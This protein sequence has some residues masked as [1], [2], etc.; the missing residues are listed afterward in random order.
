MICKPIKYCK[1]GYILVILKI[2]KAIFQK[3]AAVDVKPAAYNG[4]VVQ[5]LKKISHRIQV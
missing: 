2:K 3:N 1:A 5:L 4:L